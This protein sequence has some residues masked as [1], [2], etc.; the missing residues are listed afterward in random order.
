[1]A[2]TEKTLTEQV[3]AWS[4]MDISPPLSEI[5][6]LRMAS[7]LDTGEEALRQGLYRIIAFY[8]IMRVHKQDPISR[9]LLAASERTHPIVMEIDQFAQVNQYYQALMNTELPVW[10]IRET[11]F[12]PAK[13]KKSQSLHSQLTDALQAYPRRI[14][15]ASKIASAYNRSYEELEDL[16][17]LLEQ[18]IDTIENRKTGSPVTAMNATVLQ[19]LKSLT[20][21]KEALPDVLSQA[22][23]SRPL[24]VLDQLIGLQDVKTYIHDYY[25]YL[26]YQQE[27]KQFGF[28]MVDEPGLH[29]VITG[30][31][32][33][34]KTTIAR[35]LAK[36]Y[37][38]LGLLESD[39][40]VEVNRSHLVGSY[41]GQ[42]EENTT[43]YVRQAIGGVLF[44]DEAYSLKREGQSGN[45][46]GQAV[47][48]T[49]VSSMTSSEYG[50]KFAVILAG[51]PEETRQFLFANPGLRSR[52]PDQNYI[53]L[54]DFETEEL[55]QIAE[56][57]A[58]SNDFFFTDEAL[59]LVQDNIEQ[60]RVDDTFGNA[61]TVRDIV[62]RIIFQKGADR[63]LTTDSWID[64]MTLAAQ[65]VKD[66]KQNE[67]ESEPLQQLE[68]LIGLQ[69]IKEEVK[70]LSSF[71]QI[72]QARKSKGAPAVPIQ[73]HA[74][75]TGNP[76]TG[77]TTIAKIYA[78][79]LKER[80]LLKRG[81][82]VVA[83]RSDLVAGY[84]GQTAAKT[85]TVIR[86]ALGGVLFIDEAY[87]LFRGSQDFGKEAIDTLVDEMTKHNENLV[88]VLAGYQQEMKQF[89]DSNPGL[90][91]RFKKYFIFPDYNSEELVAI[92]KHAMENYAYTLSE[93]AEA[94]LKD[95]LEAV[96]VAGNA[97]FVTNL[98]DEAIQFQSLR[99]VEAQEQ[100]EMDV[101]EKKDIENAWEMVRRSAL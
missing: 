14:D 33:T 30:N 22:S 64:H 78:A 27:R 43:N 54:P 28:Q 18:T 93:E 61:R 95:R 99:L 7:E 15:G 26:R 16:L 59:R 63:K 48:D 57:T 40:V 4:S 13:L 37:H 68:Q 74:V 73:L 97:R 70:K 42:S 94:F 50:G 100:I 32:G 58:L 17:V 80:G 83:S 91:S 92:F 45:D 49:L 12:D 79:I 71:V 6:A 75:F 23:E 81:H 38:Q 2:Q 35:L 98:L 67:N 87:S 5:E 10:S 52:I 41:L 39:H 82:L 62:L 65:D 25:H 96:T 69:S 20:A 76:G 85:K 44:I 77:K 60:A 36:L 89:I 8:R 29:M 31:P 86:D 72:Q 55:L 19:I 66:P 51:Y 9:Q 3:I 1:M 11:D 46:Y 53:E 101:L 90:A 88:V 24:E 34:G 56:N 21:V 47:I 84:V